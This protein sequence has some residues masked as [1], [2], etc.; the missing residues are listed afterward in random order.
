LQLGQELLAPR[1]VNKTGAKISNGKVVYISGAQGNRPNIALADA[2]IYETAY[3]TIGIATE[4]I[5]NNEEGFV[6]TFGIVRGIDTSSWADGTCLYL[7]D[8]AGG[9]TD[10]KPTD[11]KMRITVGMVIK[12]HVTDGHICVRV[13]ND[14]YMFGDI[15]N[16]NYS[17]FEDD[18][19][20]VAKGL[21]ITYRD[22]YVG[23]EYFVPQGATAPGEVNYTI[24]GIATR[25]FSFDGNNLAETLSNTFEV[26]HDMEITNVNAGTLF[27]EAHLHIAP[28]TNNTGFARFTFD[29]CLIKVNGAPIAG[30]QGI[31]LKEFTA[32]KQYHN[33]LVGINLTVPV[34]GFTIGDLIE[35]T[36]TRT[37]THAS[38]TYPD[39]TIFYKCALHVPCDTLGSRT[40][41]TK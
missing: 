25:K 5:N 17:Y 40:N 11:G 41:Y 19:T 30:T 12:S 26:P 35:F 3:K 2:D 34:G 10:T 31:F 38:D 14:K 28:S 27:L 13:N 39:D 36:L 23:G 6:T 33:L 9:L 24:G 4:D 1:C 18:G 7:S 37:P 22:E 20:Y 32:N 16:S 8:T 15:T 21:A 29:W